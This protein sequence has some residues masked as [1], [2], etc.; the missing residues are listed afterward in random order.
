[1]FSKNPTAF[2]GKLKIAPAT[3]PTIADNASTASPASLLSAFA[4][5]F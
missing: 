4:N 1:M 3:L 5:L 2:P